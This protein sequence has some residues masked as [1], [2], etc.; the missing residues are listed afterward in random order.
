MLRLGPAL[1]TLDARLTPLQGGSQIRQYELAARF[2][3]Q[4]AERK[5]IPLHPYFREHG[6]VYGRHG[7]DLT[8]WQPAFVPT[9]AP[10]PKVVDWTPEFVG[11]LCMVIDEVLTRDMTVRIADH[12]REARSQRHT[13]NLHR[14]GAL[15]DAVTRP[16][17]YHSNEYVNEIDAAVVA[18]LYNTAYLLAWGAV[19]PVWSEIHPLLED[20][21]FYVHSMTTLSFA[22]MLARGHHQVRLERCGSGSRRVHDVTVHFLEDDVRVEL[23]APAQL[24]VLR[25]GSGVWANGMSDED[26]IKLVRTA[27][28]R[29]GPGPRGQLPP[30]NPGILLLGGYSVSGATLSALERAAHEFLLQGSTGVAHLVGIGFSVVQ[31]GKKAHPPEMGAAR[32]MP[33]YNV[34]VNPHYHGPVRRLLPDLSTATADPSPS[35]L[36]LEA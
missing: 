1:S 29:A 31:I 26:A 8:P 7:T 20:P 32:V 6:R 22:A 5:D 16:A 24:D 12:Y 11:L 13:H 15:V 27:V 25:G 18:E 3:A 28:R 14:L 21:A 17:M 33:V 30:Q 34:Q 2:L 35:A 23:K 9:F 10:N 4:L 19:Q 36:R